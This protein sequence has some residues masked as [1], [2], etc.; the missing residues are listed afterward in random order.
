M[1][2][3][4][5]RCALVLLLAIAVV[6]ACAERAG[7]VEA[8]LFLQQESI[9]PGSPFLALV[10]LAMDEGWHVYAPEPGDSGLPTTVSW[11]LPA[12]F[13]AGPLRW[14]T[15]RRFEESGL[16]TRGY[17]GELLLVAEITPPADLPPGSTVT[18]RARVAWLACRQECLPGEAF[19]AATVPVLDADP[20]ADPRTANLFDA[21]AAALRPTPAGA[22]IGLL[23]ALLLAFV[24][25]LILNLMP[26]VLP[27]LSLKVVGFAN[28]A[29]EDR[30]GGLAHG[31]WYTA[32]VLVSFWV[33]AGTLAALK[34]GG[35][36]L[37][38]GFQFQD[39]AAVTAIAVVLFLLGLNLFGVFEIGVRAAGAGAGLRSRR[40]WLGSFAGGLFMTLVATP[41]TAPFMGAALGYA[42]ARPP[43]VSLAVFTSLGLGVALPYALVS[44]VPGLA[45]LLPKPG[46][47]METLKQVMGFP[48]MA[49]AAWF[50]GLAAT[51]GGTTVVTPLLAALLAAGLGAWI[52]GRWGRVDRGRRSR[53]VAAVVALLLVGSSL[54]IAVTAVRARVGVVAAH[55]G[56]AAGAW[57]PWSP[58]RVEELRGEGTP[59]FVDFTAAWCL[60]CQLNEATTLNAPR[61]LEALRDRGVALLKADWTARDPSIARALERHGRAGV[62]LYVLYDGEGGEPVLL[63]EILT[64]GI[65]FFALEKLR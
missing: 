16:V 29:S 19:L 30:A 3:L 11:D 37:G 22:G 44:T 62:P 33:I 21:A 57:E 55:P 34:A 31:L 58:L 12:G 38:W 13:T 20:I 7:P 64:P 48:M 49:A 40:G 63:P 9:R 1:T 25:G 60:T 56:A 24:G 47:W 53:I 54:V 5:R 28:R 6:P 39:P 26:C 41:C 18:V 4:V 2:G 43:L 27:V 52:W 17:E 23:L 51:L 50:V 59:V 65:I 32:G 42:L 46:P 8:G 15:P 35:R 14:P 45:R 36:L 10:R 61:V